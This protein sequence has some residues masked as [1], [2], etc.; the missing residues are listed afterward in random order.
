MQ[1]ETGKDQHVLIS[2]NEKTSW[3]HGGP[4]KLT[5][6]HGITNTEV[7]PASP[8]WGQ[9]ANSCHWILRLNSLHMDLAPS[10]PFHRFHVEDCNCASVHAHVGMLSGWNPRG[11]PLRVIAADASTRLECL[12]RQILTGSRMEG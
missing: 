7:H 3:W 5:G 2:L 9:R 11:H 1:L 12:I 4:R 10:T 8:L 6:R